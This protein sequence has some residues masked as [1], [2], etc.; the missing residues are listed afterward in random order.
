L[1]DEKILMRT[2]LCVSVDINFALNAKKK[3]MNHASVTNLKHGERIWW[4]QKK[5]RF[6]VSTKILHMSDRTSQLLVINAKWLKS[7]IHIAKKLNA[8][9]SIH[10]FVGIAAMPG[11]KVV[12]KN[13]KTNCVFKDKWKWERGIN[14]WE[15]N[16]CSKI[17]M[18]TD[19]NFI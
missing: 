11:H 19:T 16:P 9:N 14:L 6:L 17:L 7:L 13:A 10:G 1:K 18:L 3:V 5:L 12:I 4:N 2:K 15:I 8:P